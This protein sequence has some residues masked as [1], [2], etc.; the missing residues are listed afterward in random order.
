[1]KKTDVLHLLLIAILIILDQFIKYYII[2]V[3]K[4]PLD[5]CNNE[6]QLVHFHP[7]FNTAGNAIS[8]RT[9]LD[10]S[11]GLF[12]AVACLGSV[13]VAY[14]WLKYRKQLKNE[15]KST[16]CLLTLDLVLAGTLGRVVERTLWSYTLDYI[17]VKNL[18][19]FYLIVI[20]LFLG[21]V[22]AIIFVFYMDVKKNRDKLPSLS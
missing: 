16:I 5:F 19:I 9:G 20:Y 21:G 3:M 10:F 18:A 1:M 22:G 6:G 11:Q 15:Q 13:V 12:L 14:Y 2:F 17:A 7:I 8:L 4:A